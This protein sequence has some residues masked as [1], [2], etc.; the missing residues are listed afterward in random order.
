MSEGAVARRVLR[1]HLV[2][3]DLRAGS[4]IAIRIDQTLTQDATG[5]L[6][7]L[8][9]EALGIDRVRCELAVSYVDHNMLQASFENADDHRFLRTFAAKHGLVY[10]RPGNGICHQV[11]LE[12]FSSPGKTLLGADS[13]TPTSGGMG[14]I[15]LGAG[16]LDIAVAMAGQP[17]HLTMPKIV[18]VTL[19][20]RLPEWVSAKDVILELLRR[21]TVKGGVGKIF[22]Y[23]GPGVATLSVPERAT[24]A[25]MGA[26]LGATT[27]IFPSD[28]ATLRYLR[29]QGRA[30][31]WRE[32]VAA[33]DA[34]YDEEIEIDLDRLE[35]LIALPGQPDRVVPVREVAGRPIEQVAIGSCTN[36]SYRDLLV[37]AKILEG[38]IVHP[39][40]SF[41]VTPGSRQAFLMAE[42][43]GA[44]ENFIEAGARVLESS[45]GPCIGMGQ[46]PA[47]RSASLRSFNRNFRGRSGTADADVYL[48]SPEVCAA[49]VITGC[50]T[51]P[52]DLGRPCPS[53]EAIPAKYVIDDRMIVTPPPDGSKV[54]V[55]R[56]PN[57]APL[58]QL[59]PLPDRIEGP[60]LIVTGDDVT[61][62]DIM[63]AGAEILPLRSNIPS[64]SR[65][66]FVRLDREFPARA[67]A[68]AQGIVVGGRNYGQGS[69]RE[70]AALVPRYL[71]VAAVVAIGFARIHRANLV[72]FGVLP[73]TFA[74]P[75]DH[76]RL[77]QGEA[78]T[79]DGIRTAIA[80]GRTELRVRRS[81]GDDVVV[82]VDLTSRER[83]ILL[84][85][86]L[87][88]VVRSR[89]AGGMDTARK[90]LVT[91]AH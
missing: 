24:I 79:I 40:V 75:A 28:D 89:V 53:V 66:A 2:D 73:L 48:A 7:D 29:A 57:I 45:C 8:Q 61:T 14:M 46:A 32:I 80:G 54:E 59:G 88:S 82:R 87:L 5:T 22:E 78:I 1:D 30:D 67:R 36:S 90:G 3:G 31:A 62:D 50:I 12:R 84:A 41:T 49:A 25:N 37:V 16:G 6:A 10:S 56:G 43:S 74:D 86:G 13:H 55:L 58:P 60:V 52:R 23:R 76:G 11:H 71:G 44:V 39:T 20:G 17:F 34:T 72:N 70:H 19:L 21:L 51:D 15:A 64:I 69:A 33:E 4:E 35:P 27:S 77:V 91:P 42:V 83:E 81:G 26:E 68:A 65:F 63:P 9:F 85:G 38:Q 47:S 18:G